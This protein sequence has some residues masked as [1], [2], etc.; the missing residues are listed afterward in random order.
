KN[1]FEKDVF[2]RALAE[3]TK[4]FGYISAE[5]IKDMG[6][7]DRYEKV[8]ND[9]I[10]GRVSRLNS[11]N[12]RPAFFLDRDGVINKEVNLLNSAEQI[13]LIPGVS[14]AVKKINKAGYLA[15]VVTNQPVIARNLCGFDDLQHI[16]DKIETLLG[17]ERAYLDAIYFCPHHPDKGY[18]EERAEYKIECTCRKP[19]PGMLLQ[20]A[21]D[22]NIDLSESYMIGDRDWDVQAGEA[23]RVKKSVKIPENKDNALLDVVVKL[24][25]QDKKNKIE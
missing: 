18:P 25:E 22:W 12:K 15:I 5:Y 21:E 8:S 7:P 23:A 3:K 6:T 11:K 13:E 19:K 4:M 1:G 20:A 16:H 9:V 2:Q 24:I 17:K 10:S 14:E